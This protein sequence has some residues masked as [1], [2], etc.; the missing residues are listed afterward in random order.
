V[1]LNDNLDALHQ[2]AQIIGRIDDYKLLM[3]APLVLLPLLLIFKGSDAQAKHSIA[4][5]G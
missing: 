5:E 1:S 3:I 2:Q 4:I